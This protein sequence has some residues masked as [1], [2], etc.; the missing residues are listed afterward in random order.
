M[1]LLT[2]SAC[3]VLLVRIDTPFPTVRGGVAELVEPFTEHAG[4]VLVMGVIRLV[5]L[6]IAGH[7]ACCSAVALLGGPSHARRFAAR[8]SLGLLGGTAAAAGAGASALAD[9]QPSA[10]LRLVDHR[11]D[12]GLAMVPVELVE[13]TALLDGPATPTGTPSSPP[14]VQGT[15]NTHLVVEGESFWSI[16]ADRVGDGDVVD[17]WLRLIEMNRHRLVDPDNPDLIH[18]GLELDLPHPHTDG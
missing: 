1:T 5:A 12:I 15:G 6:V 13:P 14:P 17:H 7:L 16:A 18:P 8:A 2:S 11:T 4:P 3:A 10:V 9:E